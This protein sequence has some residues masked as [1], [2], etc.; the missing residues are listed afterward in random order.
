MNNIEKN[1]QKYDIKLPEMTKPIANY[2]PFIISNNFIFI[3][4]QVPMQ[5]GVITF[6][7]KVGKDLDI[8][9]AKKAS[10]LCMLN[11][12]AVLNFA[13]KGNLTSIKKCL[14]ITVFVNSN[15]TFIDQPIV[16]DGAS[17][18]ISNIMSPHSE[19]SRSAVS[20]NSLPKNSAVEIDSI[21]EIEVEK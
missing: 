3:S 12:F 13:V 11:S 5:S 2:S 8:K 1:L 18:L 10:R 4:G 17:D 9:T 16:A 7:G 6:K 15:N 14:K 20:V 19:H 21:F